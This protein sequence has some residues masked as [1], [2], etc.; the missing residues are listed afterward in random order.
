LP[1]QDSGSDGLD[2]RRTIN[3]RTVEIEDYIHPCNQ[4]E[5]VKIRAPCKRLALIVLPLG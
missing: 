1:T 2:I 5:R 3:Q 4:P